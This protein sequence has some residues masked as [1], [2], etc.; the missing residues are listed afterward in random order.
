MKRG[1]LPGG[2]AL[3]LLGLAFFLPGC[4]WQA[5][6]CLGLAVGDK[7]VLGVEKVVQSSTDPCDME[8]WTC[9]DFPETKWS[10]NASGE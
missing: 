5:E 6:R 9:P 3:K 8:L 2:V 1:A 7:L 10:N 4:S